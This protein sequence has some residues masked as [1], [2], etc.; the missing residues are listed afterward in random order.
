MIEQGIPIGHLMRARARAARRPAGER[1]DAVRARAARGQ[2]VVAGRRVDRRPGLQAELVPPPVTPAPEPPRDAAAPPAPPAQAARA[3]ERSARRPRRRAPPPPVPPAPAACRP[4]RARRS[5]VPPAPTPP[6]A[7]VPHAPAPVEPAVPTGETPPAPPAPGVPPAP[8]PRPPPA[9][10]QPRDR[11][12]EPPE[13]GTDESPVVSTRQP[14]S[15]PTASSSAPT[16]FHRERRRRARMNARAKPALWLVDDDDDLHPLGNVV[17]VGSRLDFGFCAGSHTGAQLGSPTM[18]SP[19]AHRRDPEL[20]LGR[21]APTPLCSPA[22]RK[23]GA[24]RTRPS[25]DR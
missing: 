17:P 12:V 10:P 24:T 22:S 21:V 15:I 18:I 2:A 19:R 14:P 9:P 8:A 25:R 5:P 16:G 4:R 7:R 11:R 3:A 20:R 23:D 13:P 6:V 1:A